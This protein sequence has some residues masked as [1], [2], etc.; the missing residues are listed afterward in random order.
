MTIKYLNHSITEYTNIETNEKIYLL[1]HWY[2]SDNNYKVAG[3][4]GVGYF[5]T[6][7]EAENHHNKMLAEGLL[8]NET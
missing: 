1:Q 5:K 6:R 4:R 2:I 3:S 7:E 8:K